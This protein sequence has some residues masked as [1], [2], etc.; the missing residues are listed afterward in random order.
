MRRM[1]AL[2]LASALLALPAAGA[3]EPGPGYFATDNVEWL[4]NIPA[5]ADSAGSRIH[6]GYLY[7]TDDR[8]LTIYDL[9]DPALPVPVGFTPAP[10]SPYYVEEDPDTN[11]E[12]LLSSGYSDLT[13]GTA[14]SWLAVIDVRNK[15]LPVLRGL[16]RDPQAEQHSWSCVLDCTWAYGN[17]GRIADL[18]DP[19]N[20]TLSARRWTEATAAFG[21]SGSHD[22]T[23]I[24]PGLVVTSSNPVLLL[25]LREDPEH[26]TVLARGKLP[27]N[28]FV[29]GNLWPSGG[30][31]RFLLVGGETGGNC[32]SERSGAFMT[33]D[34]AG[35]WA[36]IEDGKLGEFTFVDEH[37][38]FTGLYPDGNSPYDQYCAH[39]FTEHPDFADGGLVAMGWYEHGVRF[40]DVA[41]DGAITEIG[42]F[43]PLGGSTSAAYWVTDEILYTSDY[44]R[45]I[46]IL[47]FTGEPATAEV[48]TGLATSDAEVA[49]VAAARAGAAPRALARALTVT[50]D[51]Y[52][53]PLPRVR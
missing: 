52:A 20:P 5:N 8:G 47:R 3:G 2:V 16:L 44:Q 14:L 49:R 24:A 36:D 48:R 51:P 1:T 43:L 31:D 26:P 45:G 6:D 12:I 32:S 35:V 7:I 42:Y 38:V 10:Q 21:V 40:L 41:E 29:H 13:A 23:E 30:D 9:S 34:T 46:D 27:D 39:W 18:R 15:R 11:G 19:D 4:G 25:D 22:V 53:C 33:F 50:S 37:R 17:K 28:R